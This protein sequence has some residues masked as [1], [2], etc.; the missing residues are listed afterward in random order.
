[1]AAVAYSPSNP[2]KRIDQYPA[3][4]IGKHPKKDSF[5]AS[6]GQT[7][8]MLAA[9]PGTGKGVGIVIPNLLSYPD[10]VV[11]NDPK[12]ENWDT[13][14]GFRAAMGHKVLRFSPERMETHRWNPLARVSRDPL[15]R[16]G[17]IR[18]LASVLF[19]SENPKNQEWYNKA[20]NVFGAIILYLMETP[21]MPCTLP[22]VYEIAALGSA[23]GVW[24]QQIIE[25]RS[26]GDNALSVECLRELNGVYE[27][28]K[29][30]SSGWSTT[31]DI[32]RDTLAMYG[33]KTVAWAVSGDD[34]DFS[35][36]REEKISIYFCVN[37][38]SLK[39]Y[40]P[41]MNLFFTQAIQQNSKILPE[42]GGH[43]A[44]GSLRLK[45]QVLFLIDEIAIMGR[46]EIMETAPAL[47]RGAGLR[48]LIIFQ[49]KDQMRAERTYGEQAGNGI[50]KAF[51]IEVVYSTG[52]IKLA[53]EYSN[54]LGKK[55]VPVKN[56]SITRGTKGQAT[57]SYREEPRPLMLPQEVNEMPY[58]QE[59]IFVQ[60]TKSNE[61]IKIKARKIFWYEEDVFKERAHMT[62][63]AIPVGDAS[64]IDGLTVPVRTTEAK[65]AMAA[66]HDQVLRAEHEK[67]T[68]PSA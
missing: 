63:P 36:L 51:H 40:G 49:G 22:Q 7:F 43:C 30:K 8:L 9:P 35:K 17:E 2:Q 61:P 34:I 16:L 32:V 14:A 3:L 24:A 48:Y 33:E 54:R 11:V 29:N 53:E 26:S 6:Y 58:D 21:G 47:T 20:A 18:T 46:M 28:S 66:P 5:L 44:D 15:Y 37:S 27:A 67:R 12:F 39:K 62:P 38:D 25:T 55:T 10:S 1:M 52:D 56:T 41:L 19:V 65:A 59:L 64:I 23:M 60:G 4:L 31:A 13:T 57:D 68:N 45:Y 42:Q 50:M